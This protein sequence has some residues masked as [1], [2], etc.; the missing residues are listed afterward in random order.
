MRSWPGILVVAGLATLAAG[1]GGGSKPP[2]VASLG[3]TTPTTTTTSGGNQTTGGG[4][5]LGNIVKFAHCMQAHGAPVQVSPN[6]QGV[7]INGV[8]SPQTKA[9]LQA[10]KTYLPNGG[11]QTLSPAQQAAN[12]KVLLTM[13]KCVRAHGIPNFP[14]PDGKGVFQ[15]PSGISPNSPQFQTAMQACRPGKGA[16]IAIAFR[17]SGGPGGAVHSGS[18]SPVQGGT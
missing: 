16:R 4:K 6:G 7:Q 5:Q 18:I 11:P 9:A 17:V 3:P 10:C 15:L 12:L 1:C 8:P 14:D 13:A 2:S